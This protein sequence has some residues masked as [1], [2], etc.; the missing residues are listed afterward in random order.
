MEELSIGEVAKSVGIRASAIRYYESIQLLPEPR[1]VSGQ[2]RYDQSTIDTLKFIQTARHLGFTLTEIQSLLEEQRKEQ[3]PLSTRWQAL[4]YH[5]L[6][7]IQS[8][9]T[10]AH[11]LQ[12]LLTLGQNCSCS[13]LEECIDC[14]LTN[15]QG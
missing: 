11:T 7:E 13:N 8:I 9:I 15:C 3:A 14:V 10:R 2:R 5:K 1:R 4:V 6:D 12:R